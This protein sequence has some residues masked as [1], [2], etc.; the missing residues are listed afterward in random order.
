VR[1]LPALAAAA[2]VVFFAASS[3]SRSGEDDRAFEWMNELPPGAVVHLRDGSGDITIRR[4][5]GQMAQV[6][7]NR[8]WRHGRSSDI[9][10]AVNQQGNDYYVCAMWRGSGRCAASGYRGA[11]SSSFLTMF[12]LFHRRTDA[13]ADFV[14]ELPANVVVDARTTNGSVDIDGVQSGVTAHTV[15]GTIR[16]A[17]VA[18]PLAI[19]STNGNVDV[20]ASAVGENDPIRLTATNGNVT[21]ELPSTLQGAFDL[22]TVNGSVTSDLDIPLNGRSR[23]GRHLE[24]QIG[25]SSRVVRLHTVNGNVMLSTAT[26]SGSTA[27]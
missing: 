20:S 11:N 2:A 23:A 22:S 17:N 8:H 19:S 24:G 4:A 25:A 10:F 16:A 15:N 3:C 13:A 14:A 21:A 9:K 18:G 5:S 12:S 27:Q 7:G 6:T 1:T 26:K